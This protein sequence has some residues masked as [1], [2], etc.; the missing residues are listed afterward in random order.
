MK[1][2]AFVF[3]FSLNC[4]SKT[5]VCEIRDEQIKILSSEMEIKQKQQK[6]F[7]G[8]AQLIS[9]YV[10]EVL[11]NEYEVEAYLSD[12]D[13]R[14]YA[15]GTLKTLQDKLTASLWSRS[16]LVELSCELMNAK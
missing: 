7:L 15:H 8:K 9:A 13:I 14:I 1:I 2:A 12:S 3:L 11:E 6:Y 5:V 10:T 4:F 16:N